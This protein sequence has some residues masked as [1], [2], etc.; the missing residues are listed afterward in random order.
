MITITSSHG[1]LQLRDDGTV[2][3]DKTHLYEPDD[4]KCYIKNIER[5]NLDEHKEF[6][7]NTLD[8]CDINDPKTI[9]SEFETIDILSI[10]Y[11]DK[12][13][14]YNEPDHT[15]RKEIYIDFKKQKLEDQYRGN[16]MNTVFQ[17][18]QKTYIEN[19]KSLIRED[20]NNYIQNAEW[21]SN[22]E[23]TECAVSI[24]G[25][26]IQYATF[27]DG[28]IQVLAVRT[29]PEAIKFIDIDIVDDEFLA[30]ILQKDGMALEF[31]HNRRKTYN[32]CLEAV[33][34]NP[35]AIQFVP[36]HFLLPLEDML[37]AMFVDYVKNE[38]EIFV[39]SKDA[40]ISGIYTYADGSEVYYLDHYGTN[41][42]ISIN[43]KT[44]KIKSYDSVME[45]ESEVAQSYYKYYK[46]ED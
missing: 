26:V 36:K 16:K 13:G 33:K 37:K 14:T 6:I 40:T 41:T 17:N 24:D 31:I 3:H 32:L 20:V 46:S 23:L 34:Q 8:S 2:D 21:H 11:W 10:G 25:K 30:E 5:F 42:I 19:A 9:K 15:W 39:N 1:V 29:T 18:A 38:H 12:D 7:L 4:P 45:L 22:K 27:E 44:Y 43:T 35:N 28:A